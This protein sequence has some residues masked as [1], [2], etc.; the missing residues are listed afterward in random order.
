[1]SEYL[2]PDNEVNIESQQNL[3]AVRNKMVNIFPHFTAR[4]KNTSK[5]FC[6]DK[7]DMEHLYTCEKLNTEKTVENFETLFCG[8]I[9]QQVK[10]FK[11]F[12]LNM[13]KREQFAKEES[14]SILKGKLYF[15]GSRPFL[16]KSGKT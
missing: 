4:E 10:I 11:I 13:K 6:G 7:E 16:Q 2:L 9:K 1:M 15:L 5:C 3:F 8:N 12:E 14:S